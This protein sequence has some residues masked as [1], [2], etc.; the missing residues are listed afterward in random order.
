MKISIIIPVFNVEKYIV[1]CFNSIS[2][3]SYKNIECIFINDYSQ[4]N[5]MYFLQNMISTYR[6]PI[7]FYTIIHEKNKGPSE[8][9]NTGTRLATG[10]YIYY[11]DSDDDIARDCIQQLVN[12]ASKYKLVDIVQGA[13]NT[14][15][16][17]TGR[18]WRDIRGN[19]FPKFCNDRTWIRQHFFKKP[20]IPVNAWNKLIRREFLLRN[21]LFFKKGIVHEDEHWMFFVAKKINSIAFC[22]QACYNHYIVPNSII[23][24]GYMSNRLES[25]LI[26][27]S[28]MMNNLDTELSHLQRKYVYKLMYNTI[29]LM[30]TKTY[31]NHFKKYRSLLIQLLLNSIRNSCFFESLI[32][33]TLLLPNIY[34]TRRISELLIEHYRK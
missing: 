10:E 6:G 8:T 34:K 15:P 29:N 12:T 21:N 23:Q 9:R 24:S 3:Q 27:I 31:Q 19:N 17:H 14:V 28:E 11:I 5:S 20:N 7:E 22:E 18:N 33:L 2:R 32:L 4:D 30:N 16:Q 26:V 1:R 25:M 13:T